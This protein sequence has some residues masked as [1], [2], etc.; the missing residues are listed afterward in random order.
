MQIYGAIRAAHTRKKTKK[1]EEGATERELLRVEG[2]RRRISDLK[3]GKE[4]HVWLSRAVKG[5]SPFPPKP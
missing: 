2:R 1:R 4:G 3:G 5:A